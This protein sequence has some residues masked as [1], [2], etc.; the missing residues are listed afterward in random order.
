MKM[1]R[2]I[3]ILL[4][5][6]TLAAAF[7]TGFCSGSVKV[8]PEV[9]PALYNDVMGGPLNANTAG[10]IIAV[11]SNL[12]FFTSEGKI[13]RFNLEKKLLDFLVDLAIPIEP[14]II[15]QKDIVVLKEK[16]STHFIFF[17]LGKMA[18]IETPQEIDAEKIIS[19]DAEHK[20]IGYVTG[21]RL[22]F[23]NYAGGK[24]LAELN[25]EAGGGSDI[26]DGDIIFYNSVAA[27][28]DDTPMLLVLTSRDLYVFNKT[29]NSIETIKLAS[30]AASGF[31]FDNGDMYYGSQNRELVKFSL[32]DRKVQWRFK[33]ADQLKIEPRKAGPYIVITP[34]D[35]NIY[36][37]N[38]RGTLYWWEKLDSTRLLPPV[39]MKENAAVF[40]WNK[41]IKYF[42]YKHKSSYIYP[43]DKVV[44]SN[45]LHI[46][47]YLYVIA[48]TGDQNQEQ[49]LKAITKIGNNFGVVIQTD[50]QNIIPMGRSIKFNLERFNLIK[51]ELKVNILDTENKSVFEK[52]ISYKD[53]PSFIWIPSQAMLYKLVVEIN[54]ENK[55]GLIIEHPFEVIDVEKLLLRYYYQLQKNSN[56]DPVMHY[57]GYRQDI[58]N[59]TEP[60]KIKKN[61][62]TRAVSDRKK[63]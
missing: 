34:E 44:F 51:P 54:A 12:V 18:V 13:Y 16:N 42:D 21:R 37:F 30:K 31:L 32:A 56:E 62:K 17:D 48:E 61:E 60:V 59:P 45:A 2:N 26:S 53:E 33:L 19:I 8:I 49:P 23:A 55:K 39:I 3:H 46:D 58:L 1:K 15:H 27:V 22:V 28:I 41:T 5:M 10:T 4:L 9:S 38:K 6:L 52:K 7:L 11:D 20:I 50:P 47:G 57:P 24:I 14:E 43:L 40:L 29:R 25:L 63:D 36:F 35:Q